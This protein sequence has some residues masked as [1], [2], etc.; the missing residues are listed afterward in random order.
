[1]LAFGYLLPL[2]WFLIHIGELTISSNVRVA[3]FV[4]I[5]IAYFVAWYILR[6]LAE[7]RYQHVAVYTGGIIATVLAIVALFPDFNMY[8]SILIA[9]IG[10]I[11][12]V[13]YFIDGNK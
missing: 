10:L 13:I 9:Y 8:S 6:P 2:A 4:A 11:F 1:M 3:G 12:A 5:A 7:N